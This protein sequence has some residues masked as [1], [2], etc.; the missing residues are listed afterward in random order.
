MKN[1]VESKADF[2]L[3]SVVGISNAGLFSSLRQAGIRPQDIPVLSFNVTEE[4]LKT[5]AGR[6]EDM[7]GNYSCWSYFQSLKSK[8]NSDFVTRFRDRYGATRVINDPMVAA[9][10]G[11]HLWAQAV[12]Q[13]K[14]LKIA[15]VRRS[16]V[17][18][19]YEGPEGIVT[20]DPK[21]Q[22]AR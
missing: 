13:S 15:D 8:N 17:Q 19:S 7:A 5:I 9:Y 14:S 22:I 4:E 21:T 10:C 11:I 2:I 16:F 20:I 3:N 1:I 12:E 18:Q 6:A